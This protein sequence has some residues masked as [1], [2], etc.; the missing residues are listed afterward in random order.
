MDRVMAA[1]IR[2]NIRAAVQTSGA[3]IVA[4]ARA[5][6]SWSTRIPGSI[7][8]RVSFAARGAGVTV[9]SSKR[10]APHGRPYEMGSK[11]TSGELRHPVFG[12]RDRWVPEA[13]RPFF[14]PA[15]AEA[16]PEMLRAMDK[17]ITDA[18]REAGFK[19]A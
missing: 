2:R 6:A 4:K 3:G 17:A 5:N 11:G 14:F 1:G 18:V 19:G 7:R 13:T 8:M 9:V 10:A 16:T 15:V 12:H